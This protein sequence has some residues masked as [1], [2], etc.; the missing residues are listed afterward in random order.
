MC[1]CETPGADPRS[2]LQRLLSDVPC[3]STAEPRA[4][5]DARDLGVPQATALP[6]SLSYFQNAVPL[7]WNGYHP[8]PHLMWNRTPS[9][10]PDPRAF[11]VPSHATPIGCE[12]SGLQFVV[13]WPEM[14][15]ERAHTLDRARIAALL[16]DREEAVTL[17]RQAIE[18]GV[19]WG[20]G[21]WVHRDIDLESLHDYPPFQELL[22]PK[23]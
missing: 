2:C 21:V 14:L 5:R 15:L 3:H 22:R 9:R 1:S 17:L 18:Q 4:P 19:N 7:Y 20:H 13:N 23:G 10:P 11:I 12:A 8:G 16:G 6:D